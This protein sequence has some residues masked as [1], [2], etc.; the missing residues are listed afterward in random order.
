MRAH[1]VNSLQGSLK[2]KVSK[3]DQKQALAGLLQELHKKLI[4]RVASGTLAVEF[5]FTMK[6]TVTVGGAIRVA[7]FSMVRVSVL[8]AA[9]IM[10]H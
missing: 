7:R 10:Q 6:V 5:G 8:A 3:R 9:T 2:L 4:I 1:G